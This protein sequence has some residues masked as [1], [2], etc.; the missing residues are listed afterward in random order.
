MFRHSITILGID[1]NTIVLAIGIIASAL[2]ILWIRRALEI[3]P[4]IHSFRATAPP[5]PNWRLRAGLWLGVLAA[6][7]AVVAL[8]R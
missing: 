7:L 2:G 5:R 3:E 6:V 1:V 8:P 4:E